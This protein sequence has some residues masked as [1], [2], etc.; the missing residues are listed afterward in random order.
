MSYDDNTIDWVTVDADRCVLL[1][2]Q[3]CA[4]REDLD[5]FAHPHSLLKSLL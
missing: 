3:T 1:S 5:K 2:Y 4:S